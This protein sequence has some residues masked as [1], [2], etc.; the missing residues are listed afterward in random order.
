MKIN[1]LLSYKDFRGTVEFSAQDNIL[2]GKV[3]GIKSLISYEGNSLKEL[4]ND[5]R[6]AVDDYLELCKS[7]NTPPEKEYKGSFNVRI[8]PE[9]HKKLDYLSLSKHVSI[10]FLV[11]EAISDYVENED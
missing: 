7:E 10:N 9:L 1:N 4:E 6:E 8:D 2:Y 11:E 3:I 5:F